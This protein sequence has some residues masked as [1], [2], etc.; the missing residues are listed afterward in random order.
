[1]LKWCN[2]FLPILHIYDLILLAHTEAEQSVATI[3][4]L[5]DRKGAE[6]AYRFTAEGRFNILPYRTLIKS[7]ASCYQALVLI[8]EVKQPE[9]ELL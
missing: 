6:P 5:P 7:V 2:L 3:K 4:T 9:T 8:S 1:M